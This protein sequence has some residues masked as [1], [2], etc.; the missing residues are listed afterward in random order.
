MN[1][2]DTVTAFLGWCSIFNIAI[3]VTASLL[4]IASKDTVSGIHGKLFDLPKEQIKLVYF[5][6][7]GNYK[8]AILIFNLI[9][10]FALKVMQ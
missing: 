2:I 1:T 6:Y 4:L 7:L 9:P 8:I 5:Q 3:F 10:Y